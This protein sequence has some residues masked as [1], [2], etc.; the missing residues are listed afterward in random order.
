MCFRVQISFTNTPKTTLLYFLQDIQF[1]KILEFIFLGWNVNYQFVNSTVF[2]CLNFA[3][4]FAEDSIM[5][6]FM[7]GENILKT[8]KIVPCF[9]CSNRVPLLW[10]SNMPSVVILPWSWHVTNNHQWKS[11]GG[12]SGMPTGLFMKAANSKTIM[13]C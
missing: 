9:R 13:R 10:I 8:K 12:M 3:Y 7:S 4:S 1:F 2:P 5:V 6:E 11:A